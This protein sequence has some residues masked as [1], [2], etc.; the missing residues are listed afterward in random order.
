MPGF[1]VE[2]LRTRT[3]GQGSSL[4]QERPLCNAY[5]AWPV[6]SPKYPNAQQPDGPGHRQRHCRRRAVGRGLSGPAVLQSFNALQLSAGRYLVYGLI[7]VALLLPRWRRLA[8]RLGRAEWFGLLWLSLAGNLVYFL[9]LATAVQWAGGAAASLIVGLI[10]VVVTL[11]GVREQGR[12]AEAAA[13]GAGPVRSGVA[14]VGWESLM[15]EHL[16]TPWRQRVVGLLCAFGA[17]FSWALYSIGNSRWLAR[18][19]D[20]SSHDWS[21]LTGV[22]TGGLALLLVPMAFIGPGDHGGAVGW[23]LGDQRRRGSGGLDPRQ[24]VLEPC[25]PPAA[26]DPDR[27][28]DRVRN[29]VR[30]AVC[31]RLA[32]ALAVAA[33]STG[34]R[35]PGGRRDAVR[36]CPPHAAGDRRTCR[37]N[38]V[39]KRADAR[40]VSVATKYAHVGR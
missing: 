13:A 40:L 6:L 29:A 4:G 16:A 11:V 22:T 28:D 27:A 5:T 35:V 34:D 26:I 7:A 8:P 32:T 20:L 2:R 12:A 21:L 19:P 9:L 14:L 1:R 31:L 38:P 15:S 17:L 33:G 18:R 25:Q 3:A 39:D 37:L 23:L 36:A 30:A 24:R 10:P